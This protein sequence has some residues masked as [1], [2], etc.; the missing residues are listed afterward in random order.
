MSHAH[1]ESGI[2][3]QAFEHHAVLLLIFD[4]QDAVFGFAGRQA[5]DW[6]AIGRERHHLGFL[7]TSTGSS[8]QNR[9]P[10]PGALSTWI[11]PPISSTNCRVIVRPRP[12]PFCAPGL[13]IC[14]NASKIPVWSSR[15]M[16]I[17]VS[18]TRDRQQGSPGVTCEPRGIKRRVTDPSFGVLDG[19]AK[20]V[21]QHLSEFGGISPDVTRALRGLDEEQSEVLRFRA[22]AHHIHGLTHHVSQLKR[23]NLQ[24]G[25]SCLDL[26]DVQHVVNQVE[27]VF[28]A[29]VDDVQVIALLL[30]N[31]P[32]HAAGWRSREW[33]S[34]AYAT[35]GSCWPGR[36]SWPDWLPPR[37]P[38][39]SEFAGSFRDLR[40]ESAQLASCK[41]LTRDR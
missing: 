26:G 38:W 17:P 25:A 32:L 7:R 28:A 40:F 21:N 29:A 3:E 10:L 13:P 30:G 33:H 35:R 9:D 14:T 39:R 8:T 34:E 41:I 11:V 5:D 4:D 31:A 2:P 16:P 27:Q 12:V 23:R 6:W 19:I 22:Q 15:A 20:K 37:H 18:S 1:L 36:C 24:Y